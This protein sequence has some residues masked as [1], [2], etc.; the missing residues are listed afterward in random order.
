MTE[1]IPRGYILVDEALNH[2]GRELFPSEWTGQEQSARSGLIGIDEWLRIRDLP[3][4]RGSD[5]PGGA[6][7]RK[8]A[9]RSNAKS[10]HSTGDP[11]SD[12]YQREYRA[13]KRYEAAHDRLRVLLEG[14]DLEAAILD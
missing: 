10:P 7:P 4:A 12:S 5:A 6:P 8:A 3:P 14:G 1:F 13:A 11:S 2:L 9:T